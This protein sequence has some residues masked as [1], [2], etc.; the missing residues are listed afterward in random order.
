MQFKMMFLEW[1]KLFWFSYQWLISFS[2][3]SWRYCHNLSCWI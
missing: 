3:T 2:T 1:A